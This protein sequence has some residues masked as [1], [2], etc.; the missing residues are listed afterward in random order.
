VEGKAA[1]IEGKFL[2]SV[3]F[4]NEEEINWKTQAYMRKIILK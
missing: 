2:K 3:W 4:E 1:C